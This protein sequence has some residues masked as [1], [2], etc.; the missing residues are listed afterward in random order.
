MVAERVHHTQRH[1]GQR[2]HG[3]RGLPVAQFGDQR[4]VLHRPH[5][6][7]DALDLEQIQRLAHGVRAAL[8]AGVRDQP[9]ALG[10]GHL[11]R[12]GE[13]RGRVAHLG[14]VE[15]DADELVTERQRRA[16]RLGGRVGTVVAQEAQDQVRGD[17]AI[18][19]AVGQRGGQA[20]EHLGQRHPV[21]EV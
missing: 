2:A 6:V 18:A 14:G 3:Q 8:L 12:A 10:G 20:A 19:F 11:V 15:P 9:Q 1:V 17:P 21:A 4:G 16:E 5:A 13:Q 7:V